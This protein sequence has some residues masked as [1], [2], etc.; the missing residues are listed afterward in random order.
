MRL[1]RSYF[2][3]ATTSSPPVESLAR[4]GR[5]MNSCQASWPSEF[6]AVLHCGK[7]RRLI[8]GL[9]GGIN[10]SA[11]LKFGNG[12]LPARFPRSYSIS[13]PLPFSRIRQSQ[14]ALLEGAPLTVAMWAKMFVVQLLR[15]RVEPFRMFTQILFAWPR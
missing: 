6:L 1:S 8:R 15:Q 4:F 10:Q 14:A 13:S 7:I 11:A 2:L 5:C 9:A 3:I 12:R